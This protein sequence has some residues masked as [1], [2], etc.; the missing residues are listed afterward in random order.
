[1]LNDRIVYP[2][3]RLRSPDAIRLMQGKRERE[4]ERERE[5]REKKKNAEEKKKKRKRQISI[6]ARRY[7]ALPAGRL[8][9][10]R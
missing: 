9:T 2:R 3:A 8:S 6:D 10:T 4:R 1:M 5:K 7:E